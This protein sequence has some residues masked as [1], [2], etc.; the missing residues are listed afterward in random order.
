MVVP[1]LLISEKSVATRGD[2]Q[3]IATGSFL[4]KVSNES[5]FLLLR[6]PLPMSGVCIPY[7][8]Y[9]LLYIYYY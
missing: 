4:A 5:D 9:Y 3:Q 8:P 1:D 7:I 6:C 2:E